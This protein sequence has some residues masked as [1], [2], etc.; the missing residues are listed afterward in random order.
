MR[1]KRRNEVKDTGVVKLNASVR[2]TMWGYWKWFELVIISS[3]VDISI[4]FLSVDFEFGK[5]VTDEV[6]SNSYS[7]IVYDQKRWIFIVKDVCITGVR[8]QFKFLTKTR[9][10][11]FHLEKRNHDFQKFSTLQ[12]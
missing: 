10:I 1:Y 4:S 3:S 11:F 7:E 6:V 12:K 5:N 2:L 9:S 8:S